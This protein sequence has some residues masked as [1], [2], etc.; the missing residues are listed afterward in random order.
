MTEV[1]RFFDAQSYS[2]GD[3]AEVQARFRSTGVLIDVA[4]RLVVSAPGGMFVSI[5]PGEAM[6]EGFWY[7]NTAALQL[8]VG[9]NTSGSTRYD[10]V[11]L[12][13]SRTGN[14]LNAAVV[15]G[16]V[17]AGA[18]PALTQIVGG[19]WELPLAVITVPTGVGAILPNM[20]TNNPVYTNMLVDARP[21][22]FDNPTFRVNQ[23]SIVALSTTGYA[24]DRWITGLTNNTGGF[25]VQSVAAYPPNMGFFETQPVKSLL[26]SRGNAVAIAADTLIGPQ[27]SLE[28]IKATPLFGQTACVSWWSFCNKVGTFSFNYE[29]FGG[30]WRYIASWTHGLANTWQFN[31]VVIPWN[32]GA[33]WIDTSAG[34]LTCRWLAVC[35][36]NY[37]HTVT[38]QWV[39]VN[40]K[41]I[42]PDHDNPLTAT[43]DVLWIYQPKLEVGSY[44]TRFEVPDPTLERIQCYRQLYVE[45]E[46][47]TGW[48]GSNAV[49]LEATQYLPVQMRVIPAFSV[50]VVPSFAQGAAPTANQ[51]GVL[52]QSSWIT[53]FTYSSWVAWVNIGA[54]THGSFITSSTVGTGIGSGQ[55]ASIVLGSNIQ[56]VYSSEL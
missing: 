11:V 55:A 56:V 8:A 5:A 32:V 27:Q 50:P 36:D 28:G 25:V 51:I 37:R 30:N 15:V 26:V 13:L 23:R 53:N 52:C 29:Q 35:G 12:R 10:R 9:N 16:T 20:I 33:G 40:G 38:N 2:E 14:T 43:A 48:V 47:I 24:A 41:Y 17:G 42:G 7:K 4:S 22:L 1:A 6:V 49:A 46:Q 54:K 3:Q 39:N 45:R 18:P 34:S 21:N 31:Y 44:P 19:I